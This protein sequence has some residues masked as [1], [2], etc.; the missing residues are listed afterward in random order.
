MAD[1]KLSE[2]GKDISSFVIPQGRSV[3]LVQWGGDWRVI[4]LSFTERP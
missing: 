1:F 4:S 3:K 2:H